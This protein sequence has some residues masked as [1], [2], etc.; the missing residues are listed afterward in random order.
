MATINAKPTKVNLTLK[1]KMWADIDVEPLSETFQIFIYDIYFRLY[2]NI[3]RIK[4]LQ[5]FSI[6]D[7]SED[8]NDNQWF[9]Y[10][11]KYDLCPYTTNN[12]EEF[13]ENANV[14]ADNITDLFIKT[15]EILTNAVKLTD[16]KQTPGE[17]WVRLKNF[18]FAFPLFY[19]T[20]SN[21]IN[22][23]NK[24]I[25]SN[26]IIK[27]NIYE[28]F[29]YIIYNIQNGIDN[30]ITNVVFFKINYLYAKDEFI[31]TDSYFNRIDDE[32]KAEIK[33]NDKNSEDILES[34]KTIRKTISVDILVNYQ[35]PTNTKIIDIINYNSDYYLIYADNMLLQDNAL[36]VKRIK[37]GLEPLDNVI[38]ND[39]D[40]SIKLPE[41][42]LGQTANILQAGLNTNWAISLSDKG[43]NIAYEVENT[44]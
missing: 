42:T 41:Q 21:N 38:L 19:N 27:H 13:L 30:I 9:T 12:L 20:S 28:D 6:Q 39:Y 31:F 10:K 7:F 15:D 23:W 4:Q 34:L 5:F 24:V 25:N 40:S 22:I 8:I 26:Q 1:E 32:L 16:T 36:K 17:L 29:G 33:N 43:I 14:S 2:E 18:P 44:V 37:R 35:I 11:P 3:E